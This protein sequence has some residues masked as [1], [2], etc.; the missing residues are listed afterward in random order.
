MVVWTLPCTS[1][2]NAELNAVTS[3]S[4][5]EGKAI[6]FMCLSRYL[7]GTGHPLSQM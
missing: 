1:Q 4:V 5:Q 2:P 3:M 7:D 6:V